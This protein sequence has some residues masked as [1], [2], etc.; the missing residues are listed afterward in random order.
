MIRSHY[1]KPLFGTLKRLSI[2]FF[3]G[4]LWPF[5]TFFYAFLFFWPLSYQYLVDRILKGSTSASKSV[6]LSEEEHEK[7]FCNEEM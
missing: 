7:M 4:M 5:F 3:I 1:E 6:N 2:Q